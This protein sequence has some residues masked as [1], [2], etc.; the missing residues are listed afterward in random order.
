MFELALEEARNRRGCLIELPFRGKRAGSMF[1]VTCQWEEVAEL[2]TWAVYEQSGDDSKMHFSKPFSPADFE[3]LFDMVA[4]ASL[5]SDVSSKIPDNL[6]NTP[7]KMQAAA[8]PP[9]QA[10]APTP[11]P[12]YPAGVDYSQMQ[13]APPGYPGYPGYYPPPAPMGYPQPYPMM[14]GYQMPGAYPGM[15]PVPAHPVDPYQAAQAPP[16]PVAPPP[17]PQTAPPAPPEP[18]KT[19]ATP[20]LSN[21][22]VFKRIDMSLLAKGQTIDLGTL[23]LNS[24]L[25]KQASLEAAIKIQGMVEDGKLDPEIA[26]LALERFHGEGAKI[27]QYLTGD[28]LEKMRE[29]SKQPASLPPPPAP[30][31]EKPPESAAPPR[32]PGQKSPEEVQRIRLAFD[33]LKKAGIISDQDIETAQNVLRKTGGDIVQILI[34]ANKFDINTYEAAQIVRPLVDNGLMKMEQ[35][36]IALNYCCRSRVDFDT[37]VDEMGWQNPRKV[38]KDLNL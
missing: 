10:A 32:K 28:V 35:V 3:L 8:P 20:L 17:P 13:A 14:P 36:I 16:T 5:D 18:V 21:S 29:K 30:V 27:D 31:K 33:M 37:A 11:P 25:V 4:M 22:G 23:L 2:P 9:Q 1:T 24:H 7:E 15:P 26:P 6:K 19:A 34:S 12:G 38:R